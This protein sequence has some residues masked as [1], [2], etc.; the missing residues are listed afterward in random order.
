MLNFGRN[1]RSEDLAKQVDRYRSDGRRESA[2]RFQR[3]YH[4]E[5]EGYTEVSGL[6]ERGKTVIRRVYTGKYYEPVL[7]PFRRISLRIVY[8]LCYVGGAALFLFCATRNLTC[9]RALYMAVFQCAAV[10][11]MLWCASAL[12]FYIPAAGKLTIGEYRFQHRSLVNSARAVSLS[13]WGTGAA[14]LVSLA[15]H[16]S[17]ETF[18]YDLLCAAGFAGGGLLVFVIFLFESHLKYNV[19]DSWESA[20][21]DGFEIE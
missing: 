10:V 3:A 1:R 4:R 16:F 2:H 8:V 6:D 18:L 11:L 19:T 12:V 9:N 21:D 7:E 5:F 20:P 15:L 14:A 13:M 17:G